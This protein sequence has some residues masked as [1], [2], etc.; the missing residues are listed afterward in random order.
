M[1]NLLRNKLIVALA[2]DYGIRVAHLIRLQWDDIDLV[3]GAI[4]KHHIHLKDET[5]RDLRA[6]K[7]SRL[8]D[9]DWVFVSERKQQLSKD[10]VENAR[11]KLSRRSVEDIRKRLNP[12]VNHTELS[13]PSLAL[14]G[15]L[16]INHGI[17]FLRAKGT[18]RV[19]VGYSANIAKR[20]KSYITESP[21]PLELLAV[22]PGT[23]ALEQLIHK[24]Y[25]AYQ[26]HNEWFDLGAPS[27]NDEPPIKRGR[28]HGDCYK[29]RRHKDQIVALREEGATI[30]TIANVI[31]IDKNTVLKALKASVS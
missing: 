30:R 28:P 4:P 8:K 25:S 11:N 3:A 31:G 6:L 18:S 7:K 19:K 1:R 17:Y 10:C 26:R 14:G 24:S 5:I 21:Y 12:C 20:L 22:I 27:N 29:Q 23:Q 16:W 15:P 13:T 9:L 2:N